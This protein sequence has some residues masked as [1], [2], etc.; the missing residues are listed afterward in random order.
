MRWFILA[1]AAMAALPPYTGARAQASGDACAYESRAWS[2][3][4]RGC[5][6]RVEL[7][8]GAHNAW[9]QTGSCPGAGV[10]S[11]GSGEFQGTL[12]TGEFSLGAEACQGGSY[13]RC[14]A[15]GQWREVSRPGGH[16][17]CPP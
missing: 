12:C 9:D 13:Q 6:K 15:N 2:M 1:A 11:F 3:G 8:C 17:G 14:E 16:P 4:F 5:F 7:R 10:P